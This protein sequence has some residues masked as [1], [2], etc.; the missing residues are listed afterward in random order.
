MKAG[1]G[2][3]EESTHRGRH[4]GQ[5]GQGATGESR[6]RVEQ[7]KSRVQ[8]AEGTTSGRKKG[9]RGAMAKNI[10]KG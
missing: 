3:E 6:G 7:G 1:E 4:K 5:E 2:R 10:K 9:S 8:E